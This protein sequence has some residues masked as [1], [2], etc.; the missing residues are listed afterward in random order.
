LESELGIPL[1]PVYC[2]GFRSRIWTTG[3]DAAHHGILHKI[4]KPA[5]SR[6]ADL[7]NII[8]FWGSDAFGPLL[9]GMG[10][11]PNYVVPF[12]SIGDLERLSEASATVQMC[13]SLGSYLASGLEEAFGVPLVRAPT[14]F[15]AQA[16]DILLRELGRITGREEQAE[17]VIE[18][19]RARTATE[20]A[21]LRE[22][23]EGYRV[24]VGAGASHGH[25]IIAL[26]LDLGLELVGS[27]SWHH[28]AST[29]CGDE[30][31]NSLRHVVQSF[32]DIPF[33]VC[34]KQP[35]R[36]VNQLRRVKP[37]LFI[38]RHAGMAIWGAR[39]GIPT[40]EVY[41]EH[42]GVGYEGLIRFGQRIEATLGNTVFV[43]NIA[44]HTRLPFT[45]WWLAQ[46]AFAMGG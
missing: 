37:D 40:L 26:A 46:E 13:A 17:R 1:V 14:P 43:S 18:G 15:G 31:A 34:K 27:C 20:I 23:L 42:Y 16:T 5:K 29:D 35:F 7:V 38:T 33:S 3:F 19:E 41:D 6:D 30:R 25:G 10:L 8:N 28:D 9:A 12:K 21:R 11:K 44:A 22:V 4:V 32:G 45:Q 39:L 2:E 24:Y 36:F